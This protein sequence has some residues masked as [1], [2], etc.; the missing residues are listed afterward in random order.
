MIVFFDTSALIKR[1]LA[2]SG[3]DVVLELWG[4][5][6]VIAASQV[7]Y[8]EMSAT[9]ARKRREQPEASA[10]TGQARDAFRRDWVGF[11]R[12][13]VDDHVHRL[14]DVVLE[15]YPLRGADSIHLASALRVRELMQDE[16]TFACADLALLAA[17]SQE[18]LATS[19]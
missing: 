1:Y 11:E 9:F 12:V 14:V 6:S 2:E 8:A 4:S 7:L 18:G 15:R 10:A 19:P 17:A 13:A 5:A 3:S 16:V